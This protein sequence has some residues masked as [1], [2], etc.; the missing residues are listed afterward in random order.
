MFGLIRDINDIIYVFGLMIL[1]YFEDVLVF[2]FI[3]DSF[4]IWVIF[5]CGFGEVMWCLKWFIIENVSY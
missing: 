2:W 1:L 4:W 3:I 5:F